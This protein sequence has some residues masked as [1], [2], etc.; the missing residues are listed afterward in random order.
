M[1]A[2]ND[3]MWR[4]ALHGLE[5]G[6]FSR[7]EPLFNTNPALDGDKCRIVEW[8]EKGYFD[9]EPKGAANTISAILTHEPEPLARYSRAVPPALERIV[10]KALRKDRE[11]RYQSVKDLLIDL[12][13]LRDEIAFE[14]KLERT[15]SPVETLGGAAVT[16]ASQ[17]AAQSDKLTAAKTE[18]TARRGVGAIELHKLGGAM[19]VL[20]IIAAAAVSYF[21]LFAP[22]IKPAINSLAVLP[23][24]NESGNSDVEYLSDGMTDSLI[25]SLS[26]LPNLSVKARSTVFRY[27]GKEIEAQK[28]ASDL[29]VQSILS[30]RVVLRG[31]DLV[32][33]LSLVDA[34][35]GN[36]LWGEQYNRRLTDLVSL[37]NEITRDVSRKLRARLSGSEEQKLTK[38]Y[39]ANADAYQLYLK[40]RYHL[41]RNTRSE[42]PI[43]ISYFEQAVAIDPSYALAYVGLADGYRSPALEIRPAEVFPKAKLAAQKALEID[44]TLAEAHAVLG[45]ITFWYDWDW[46][47]AETQFKRALELNPDSADTHQFYAHLFSS[48]E[49]HAEGLAEIKRARELDPVKLRVYA[50]EGQFLIH[51]GRTDEALV[52]LQKAFALDPNYYLAHNFAASAYIEKG[53]F[54]EAVTE[55]RKAREFSGGNNHPMTFMAYALAKSGKQA[56]ARAVLE[57]LFRLSIK[58]YVSPYD[59]AMIYNGLGERDKTFAWL[60]K[61]LQQRDV[62][63]TFL[64]VEPKWNDLRDDSRFHDLLRRVGLP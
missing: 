24:V 3:P 47:S 56:E 53:M 12:R 31:N 58:D 55:A 18:S 52:I 57:E 46:N 60:G 32:L 48:T 20:A 21:Y 2:L 54:A 38:S 1:K 49:R 64:K 11:Q 23:F 35:D 42:I 28:V 15:A 36:Q 6:D 27:K 5:R 29:S 26:Q 8:Y 44:D 17:S 59:V 41:L 34:R 45:Y 33:Y 19:V 25:N 43:A 7:L 50:L 62:R 13:D 16:T 61:A 37:Q 9:N 40:G 39:T 63:M 51:A 22:D 4:D 14:A 10:S 30:G